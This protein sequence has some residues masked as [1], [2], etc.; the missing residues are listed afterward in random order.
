MIDLSEWKTE[1]SVGN[2]TLDTQHQ[3]LLKLCKRISDYQCDCT[4]SSI[5][6]FHAILN[7]LHFYAEKHFEIEEDVLRRIGYPHLNDQKKDHDGYCER[8]V[9]FMLSAMNGD[10]DKSSLQVYLEKWWIDHILISDMQYRSY[11]TQND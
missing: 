2:K 3:R 4:K 8:L 11:L 9:G 10:I 7:D 5:E 1:Y 6:T